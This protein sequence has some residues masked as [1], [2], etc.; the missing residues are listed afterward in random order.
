[1]KIVPFTNSLVA[2]QQNYCPYDEMIIQQL[3]HFGDLLH[4]IDFD[5]QLW[6]MHTSTVTFNI[7]Y[8]VF[9]NQRLFECV[10]RR[11][12]GG[13]LRRLRIVQINCSRQLG[14]L[15]KPVFQQLNALHM[16]NCE[17]VSRILNVCHCVNELRIEG[18]IACDMLQCNFPNLHSVSLFDRRLNL[19]VVETCITDCKCYE[20]FLLRHR[21]KLCRLELS[22]PVGF[23]LMV[24]GQLHQLNELQLK[25]S[26]LNHIDDQ[27][28]NANPTIANCQS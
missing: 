27:V 23:N 21:R 14:A 7:D 2:F 9:A 28:F 25:G 18:P 13:S 12:R 5:Y 3:R 24:L 10:L 6:V 15:G 4:E 20:Q 16:V 19:I 17:F 11:C 26:L 1:M 22:I 8:Q